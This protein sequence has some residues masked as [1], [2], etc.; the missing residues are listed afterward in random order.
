MAIFTKFKYI[1]REDYIEILSEYFD[2]EVYEE[3]KSSV[4]VCIRK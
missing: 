2:L 3:G 1:S 4:Y